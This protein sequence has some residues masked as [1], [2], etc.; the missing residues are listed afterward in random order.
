MSIDPV[1]QRHVWACDDQLPTSPGGAVRPSLVDHRQPVAWE[2][3]ADGDAG[4]VAP[5]GVIDEPLHHR[6][7]SGGIDQLDMRLRREPTAEQID[8]A[9]QRGVATDPNQS[10]STAGARST[11]RDHRPQQSRKSEQDCDRLRADHIQN[12]ARAGAL[13]IEEVNAGAREQRGHGVSHADDGAKRGQGQKPVLGVDMRGVDGL[14]HALQKV[15]LTVD[16][17]LRPAGAPGGE[18]HAGGLVQAQSG[19][20][21]AFAAAWANGS[22]G[23]R[24]SLGATLE[25][26]EAILS[27]DDQG[28]PRILQHLAQPV[29]G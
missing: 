20:T 24:A 18:Q 17:A 3:I 23:P 14:G 29:A 9:P 16:D 8:V 5:A 4:I 26:A 6:R 12:L 22:D 21:P 13:R 11:G 2:R 25:C 10:K 7:F 15:P 27:C 19:G 1:S 28:R